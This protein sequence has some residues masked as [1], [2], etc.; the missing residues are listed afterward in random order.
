MSP[1]ALHSLLALYDDGVLHYLRAQLL[2]PLKQLQA[3]RQPLAGGWISVE[4]HHL[5]PIL[6][7]LGIGVALGATCLLLE[8]GSG[9]RG[10]GKWK[11][12]LPQA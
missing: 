8:L 10:A 7:T 9:R 11:E 1:L 12:R 3:D 5:L 2:A 4:M 6:T